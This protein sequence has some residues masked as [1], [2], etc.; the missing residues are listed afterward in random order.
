MS[1]FLLLSFVLG[2]VF[3]DIE[4]TLCFSTLLATAG[5][6]I[7]PRDAPREVFASLVFT[8]DPLSP[9]RAPQEASRRPSGA[10]NGP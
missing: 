9:P 5:R 3:A 7:S 1:A 6:A 4:F 10:K 8:L 2:H